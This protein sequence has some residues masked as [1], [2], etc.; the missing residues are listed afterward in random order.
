MRKFVQCGWYNAY[1]LIGQEL[2]CYGIKKNRTDE[3]ANSYEVAEIIGK[4]IRDI[5]VQ[6]QGI[7]IKLED[8]SLY[9]F[10]NNFNG[11]FGLGH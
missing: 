1:I 2:Y 9:A 10:G 5:Y 8:N 11:Q 4:K 6:F 3:L 7:I